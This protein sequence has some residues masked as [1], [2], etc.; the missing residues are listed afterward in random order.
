M[1]ALFAA[2]TGAHVAQAAPAPAL[3]LIFRRVM[4]LAWRKP[5]A[6]KA[7]L[8]ASGAATAIRGQHPYPVLPALRG[9]EDGQ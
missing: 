5:S 8:S 4:R 6:P 9:T 3:P 7:Y 1:I 2:H